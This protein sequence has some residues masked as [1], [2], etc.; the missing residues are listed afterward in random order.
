MH[1]FPLAAF[2]AAVTALAACAPSA[3]LPPDPH[4]LPLRGTKPFAPLEKVDFT[5]TDTQGRPFDF[6]AETDGKIA[7]LFFGYTFC[8][9]ICPLHMATLAAALDEVATEVRDQVALVF[10]SVDPARDTPERLGAWLAA[11]DSSFVGVRGSLAEVSEV[12]SFYRY[13]P[14]ETS[15]EEVGYTVGHPALIYAFAPDNLG[16]A[17]YGPETTRAIWAHD[18]SLLARHDWGGETDGASPATAA[19][20]TPVPAG[21]TVLDAYAPSP[22]DSAAMAIYLTVH[23][24]SAQA[25]TLRSLSSR[26][27]RSGSIH[28]VVRA[29]GMSRMVALPSLEVPSGETVR[30]EPGSLHGMLEGLRELPEVG[31]NLAV[32]LHFGRAGAVP[33][34]VRV[35]RYEDLVR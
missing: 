32:V 11:F 33:V 5:L 31:S 17:M 10:V 35:V 25:D 2:A 29:E 28:D 8:P 24:G 19:N 18:L 7:L 4:N 27:A 15:G 3:D 9:D 20:A 23:N 12:L 34:A 22:R 30:L 14:P 26:I 21:I 6:R 13:P 16:R 1:R